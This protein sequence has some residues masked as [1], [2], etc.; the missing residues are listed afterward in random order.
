MRFVIKMEFSRCEKNVV[1]AYISNF[2]EILAFISLQE[3]K[4]EK[5]DFLGKNFHLYTFSI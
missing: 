2:P 5:I 1:N 4:I 3:E